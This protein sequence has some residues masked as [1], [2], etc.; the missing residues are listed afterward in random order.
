MSGLRLR[1][2]LEGAAENRGMRQ[3]HRQTHHGFTLVELMVAVVIVGILA[4]IAYPAYTS[5]VKRSRRADAAALL[6]AVV[7]AQE[8]YRGNHSTYA[9]ADDLGVDASKFTKY[10]TLSIGGI[11]APPSLKNGYVA[12]ASVISTSAQGSDAD[13]A[14]IGVELSSAVLKYEGATASADL[15][16]NG[17]CWVR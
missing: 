1:W 9:T 15:A 16:E 17:P 4:A 7:Q 5:Q 12:T 3:S 14:K 8:R 13:C 2:G 6:T 10:Y 11:G